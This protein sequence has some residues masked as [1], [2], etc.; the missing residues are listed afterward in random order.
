[1]RTFI[2]IGKKSYFLFNLSIEKDQINKISSYMKKRVYLH[3]TFRDFS[4]P[5]SDENR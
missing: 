2:R 5:E 1:M 3:K 4:S